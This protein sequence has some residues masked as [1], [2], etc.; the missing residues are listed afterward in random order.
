MRLRAFLLLTLG[1]AAERTTTPARAQTAPADTLGAVTVTAAR[2]AVPTDEAPARATVLGREAIRATAAA[3]V[4]DLLDARAPLHVRRYGPSGLATVTTR[5][6]S[7]SQTLLLLD[8]QPVTDPQL[9]QVDLSLLP[10]ALL[11]G[12]EVMSGPA[13]GLYGSAAVGGVVHLR[14]SDLAA[15]RATLDV[16]PWGER[17]LSARASGGTARTRAVVA[18]EGAQ[19]EDDYSFADRTR[20]GSPR[21]A[22]A[23]WDSRQASLYAALARDGRPGGGRL[24]VW[25]ADAER[26]LGGD[27]TVGERQWNTLARVAATAYRTTGWGR[28]DLAGSLQRA[29]LRYATPYPSARADAIDDAG[30]TTAATLDLR[31]SR[32]I[33]GWDATAQVVGGAGR[34]EHPSLGDALDRF[35]GAAVSAQ[36]RQGRVGWFPSLRADL[37]VPA[38]AARQLALSPQLG[39]NVELAPALRIKASAAR[40]FR[41]PTLNDRFWRPGGN[42]G[43]RP[44]RAWSADAG[45][46]WAGALT[47]AELSAFATAAR[48]Q[49]VWA[50]TAAGVWSPA[51]VARTRALGLEASAQTARPLVLLK[52]RAAV[53]LGALGTLQDARDL[54]TDAPLRYVPAWTAK[55]WGGLAVGAVR[56]DVGVRAV[57]RRYT[58]ASAS[59]PLPA[60]L[61]VDA[62]LTARRAVGG[63][64][65][66]LSVAA[67][68]LTDA[69]YE[70]VQSY[71]MPP[72]HARLRL[73]VQSL[74]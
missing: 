35:V 44:E 37:Y 57:G 67:E 64:E 61:V 69:R 42:P 17:R 47:G 46:A 74:R 65:L 39:A 52:R 15:P 73:T 41:M 23:G 29:R 21:V 6:A 26:G 63:V 34:G 66:A 5:G 13:S 11:D 72:R 16:G 2:V 24:S 55:A 4:A 53:E 7:A 36:G 28:L 68:N 14:T 50:P 43:L 45:L 3:S 9:G 18:V 58:T 49:I 27:G 71:P 60:H 20:I 38:A 40:A 19:A 31:A 22:R 62:Q 12:V 59:L 32:A 48:D 54:G 51:N 33:A 30:R 56:A 10:T 1:L 70:V 8:G 25:V